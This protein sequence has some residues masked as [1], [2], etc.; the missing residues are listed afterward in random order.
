MPAGES[1]TNPDQCEIP[2]E[3][4][5]YP[6]YPVCESPV[7][8]TAVFLNPIPSRP[9]S[10]Q[11]EDEKISRSTVGATDAI[12]TDELIESFLNL[13]PSEVLEDEILQKND[14]TIG[15]QTATLS[16]NKILRSDNNENDVS[17]L[18]CPPKNVASADKPA[19]ISIQRKSVQEVLNEILVYPS[20]QVTNNKRRRSADQ[21]LAA[22]ITSDK[23]VEMMQAQENEKNEKE[24]KKNEKK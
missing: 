2:Q 5:V 9:P 10:V 8:M 18:V 6:E 24:E 3:S 15:N 16:A 11:S 1:A 19:N 20:K 23:W 21:H 14:C 12:E 17:K 22:V 4:I 13:T 7:H